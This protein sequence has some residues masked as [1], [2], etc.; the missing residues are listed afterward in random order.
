MYNRERHPNRAKFRHMQSEPLEGDGRSVIMSWSS[1][2]WLGLAT[3]QQAISERTFHFALYVRQGAGRCM[4]EG[5]R[6][7]GLWV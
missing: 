1:L 7:N 4:V 6:C 2:A 5:R 3:Q